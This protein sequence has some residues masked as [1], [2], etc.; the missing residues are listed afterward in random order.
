MLMMMP[1]TRPPMMETAREMPRTVSW[2][3]AW[4]DIII[5]IIIACLDIIRFDQDDNDDD[6]ALPL[7]RYIDHE[8]FDE[9]D[10]CKQPVGLQYIQAQPPPKATPLVPREGNQHKTFFSL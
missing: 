7:A 2:M 6:N 8:D 4:I 10:D 1:V 9:N 5:I 3:P